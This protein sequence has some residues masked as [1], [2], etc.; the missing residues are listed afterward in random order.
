MYRYR[1][2]IKE[3][4]GGKGFMSLLSGGAK[5]LFGMGTEIG[6]KYLAAAALGVPAGALALAYLA[7]RATSPAAVA[8]N[9]K[10]IAIN[11][12]ER[13]SLAQSMRDLEELRLRKKLTNQPRIHDQYI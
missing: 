3:A 6:G 10:D 4:D 12:I 11:A 8:A 13:E 9:S 7:S 1:Y 5:A 2:L